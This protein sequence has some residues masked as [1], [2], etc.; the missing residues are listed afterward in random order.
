M[1]NCCARSASVLFPLG[2]AVRFIPGHGP[3]GTLGEERRTN[4][5]VLEQQWETIEDDANQSLRE[6]FQGLRQRFLD[7]YEAYLA[8]HAAQQT[9]QQTGVVADS[10]GQA[11]IEQ[12]R[13]LTRRASGL[14]MSA[15]EREQERFA[16]TRRAAESSLG[17]GAAAL[18]QAYL[19]AE[20]ALAAQRREL[21]RRAQADQTAAQ[22]LV[23]LRR[24]HERS[25]VPNRRT[26]ESLRKR[27]RSLPSSPPSVQAAP[28]KP[29]ATG[30]SNSAKIIS[31]EQVIPASADDAANAALQS[32]PQLGTLQ[33]IDQLLERLERRLERHQKQLLRKLESLP[34]RL[35]E[36]ERH[37][38]QG[39]LKKADPLYQSISA[40]LGPWPHGAA[41]GVSR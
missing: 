39:E 28:V 6:R 36:L 17:P 26:I 34:E 18:E 21:Q 8:E 20:Q 40:T 41:L 11:L 32:Q 5:F 29:V 27:R 16:A 24:H 1:P 33:E 7:D 37:L 13:A 12:L 14:D 10:D 30:I 9:A 4:P 38:N 15:L 22:L 3:M 2:D 25:A 19:E 35:T 31:G 23:D